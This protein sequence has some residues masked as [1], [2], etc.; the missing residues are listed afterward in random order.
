[1]FKEYAFDYED[2]IDFSTFNIP[3]QQTML[4]DLSK[5]DGDALETFVKQ[6][7]EYQFKQLGKILDCNNCF[8]EFWW[9]SVADITSLHV[10]CDE[11]LKKTENKF[12]YPLLSCVSYFNDLQCYPT[13]LTN[14]DV[15]KYMFKEFDEESMMTLIYPKKHRQITFNGSLYHGVL[16]DCVTSCSRVILAI[17]LW[18]KP[19]T[20]VEY[21]KSTCKS[22]NFGVTITPVETPCA[23]KI[24]LPKTTFNA[25]LFEKFLYRKCLK[26]DLP[27]LENKDILVICKEDEA[28]INNAVVTKLKQVYVDIKNVNSCN[29]RFYQRFIKHGQFTPDICDWIVFEAEKHGNWT[30]KRHDKYPTTDLP[31]HLLP[32]VFNYLLF[33]LNNIISFIKKSYQIEDSDVN[34]K[35]LFIVKYETTKQNLLK[36]HKDR[37][38]ISFNIALNGMNEYEGGGTCFEDGIVY[39]QEKGDMIVHSSLVK[40]AG[41]PLTRGKR[42]ILVG[43]LDFTGKT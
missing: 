22:S 19:P 39:K 4:L 31:A 20:N 9:K 14:V 24:Y 28:I 43:F 5:P 18:D 27:N 25:D 26:L 2:D 37:S 40:H 42:F 29:N 8:V 7:A 36:F 41:C 32:G 23:K 10:D 15:E 12:I 38:L 3:E 16:N 6:V 34:V 21:Y 30:T 17:N 11:Y 35:D 1:M 33:A 13:L